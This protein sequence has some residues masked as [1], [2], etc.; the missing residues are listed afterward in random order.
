MLTVGQVMRAVHF[1]DGESKDRTMQMQVRRAL[2]K[3]RNLTVIDV[4]PFLTPPVGVG[5]SVP[6]ISSLS[7]T[8]ALFPQ[9]QLK[10]IRRTASA[11]QQDRMHTLIKSKH[12][13]DALKR[14]T[15]EYAAESKKCRKVSRT[16]SSRN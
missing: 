7:I 16:N 8:S 1:Q 5:T 12:Y 6:A 3:K 4:D 14:A 15:L 9:P 11:M 10:R 13:K 2:E